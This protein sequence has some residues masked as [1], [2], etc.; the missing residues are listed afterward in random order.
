[1]EVICSRRWQNLKSAVGAL[2]PAAAGL[3][4]WCFTLLG[5]AYLQI[6]L[7]S[8][9]RHVTPMAMYSQFRIAVLFHVAGAVAIFITMLILAIHV[10]RFHREA[11]GLA[12]ISRIGV[13]IVLF[14]LGLGVSTWIFKFN[15]PDFLPGKTLAPGFLIQA[16]GTLQAG[17]V[18]GHVAVGAM[19]L[20]VAV[21][22]VTY[23]AGQYPIRWPVGAT[24]LRSMKGLVA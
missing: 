10:H 20:S 11:T 19:I 5:L 12:R 9:L 1:M 14:Q 6:V 8:M 16:G 21:V 15:W 4:R 2:S 3:H 22:L 18:T 13:L 24:E 17:I 23:A 7:G